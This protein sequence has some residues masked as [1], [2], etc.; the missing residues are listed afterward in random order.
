MLHTNQRKGRNQRQSTHTPASEIYMYN[1]DRMKEKKHE[2]INS[3]RQQQKQQHHHYQLW[4]YGCAGMKW[5]EARIA[6]HRMLNMY[7][8]Q[9]FVNA[10]LNFLPYYL[11]VVNLRYAK[12]DCGRAALNVVQKHVHKF[13]SFPKPRGSLRKTKSQRFIL[14]YSISSWC[15]MLVFLPTN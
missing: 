5:L 11:F 13:R 8:L 1:N 6:S 9:C 4:D 10:A 15:Q 7:K 3:Q 2:S 14:F 12:C